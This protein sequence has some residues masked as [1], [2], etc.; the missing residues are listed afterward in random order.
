MLY[1][2]H[3]DL[4][5]EHDPAV[6]TAELREVAGAGRIEQALLDGRSQV[7]WSHHAMASM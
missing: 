6:A 5:A 2:V 1:S 3:L 7:L 4:V